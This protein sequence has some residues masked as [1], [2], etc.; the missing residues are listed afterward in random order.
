MCMCIQY[1]N[2]P[3]VPEE[4]LEPV[5]VILNKKPIPTLYNFESNNIPYSIRPI[6]HNL[7]SWLI[8]VLPFM[9]VPFYQI[10]FPG[11]TI[12]KD[13]GNRRVAINYLLETGGDN[14]TTSTY[15]EDATTLIASEVLREREWHYIQSELWHGVEGVI[16]PRVA[17]TMRL[18]DKAQD[19][20]LKDTSSF[21]K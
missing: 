21:L 6:T 5:D 9:F 11:I 14:V 1:L 10:I 2:F 12:H 4:L 17:L 8:S 13:V 20:F 19:A 15:E 7:Y 18:A 16:R 3:K